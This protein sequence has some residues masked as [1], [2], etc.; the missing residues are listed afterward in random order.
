ME[1]VVDAEIAASSGQF[2]HPHSVIW[3]RRLDVGVDEAWDLIATLE[4]LARWWIVPPRRLELEVGGAFHH[5]WA[6]V[7]HR[8]EA[9]RF[10]QFGRPDDDPVREV[11]RFE[12]RS[13]DDGVTDF[14]FID[15]WAEGI[16]PPPAGVGS[17][18]PAGPG[19][20][21]VGVLTGWHQT[22]DRLATAGGGPQP[23]YDEADLIRWYSNYLNDHVRWR[24]I[25]ARPLP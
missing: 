24:E 16:T 17:E 19:T 15:T 21:W 14:C 18:Q 6:Q 5:H 7:V 10:I 9:K 23:T 4:G 25:T 2:V 13:H 11:L 3:L 20:P 12:L 22:A 8:F 1:T